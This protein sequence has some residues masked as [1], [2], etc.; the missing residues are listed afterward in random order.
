[1]GLQRV[2]YDWVTDLI[3]SD[4]LYFSLSFS[5]SFIPEWSFFCLI[6]STFWLLWTI[7]FSWLILLP[8]CSCKM[9]WSWAGEGTLCCQQQKV[10]WKIPR[11]TYSWAVKQQWSLCPQALAGK[12]M[13]H[14]HYPLAWP[15]KGREG[16]LRKDWGGNKYSGLTTCQ[17]RTLPLNCHGV[18]EGEQVIFWRLEQ[19]C[20]L[21]P[22]SLVGI[23]WFLADERS[24]PM[25]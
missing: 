24:N 3:W 11:V 5:L 14:V 16:S 9:H 21:G 10:W 23:L 19:N 12:E 22:C 4:P 13:R 25:M 17:L 2:R 1:M 7:T 6:L 18:C 20:L 8:L 15:G